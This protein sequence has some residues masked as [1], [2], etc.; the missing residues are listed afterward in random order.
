MRKI[1]CI[2]AIA[3]LAVAAIG[4]SE[5]PDEELKNAGASSQ[6]EPGKT[7]DPKPQIQK[8]DPDLFEW[9]DKNVFKKIL[10]SGNQRF[11]LRLHHV[12]GNLEAFN[13]QWNR[14][15]SGAFVDDRSVSVS[16]KNV[17]GVLNF[18][19]QLNNN[20]Y[21]LPMDRRIAL[22]YNKGWLK[23]D[24]GDINA[25]LST[26][27]ELIR[28]TRT[29]KGAQ[30]T[31]TFGPLS[32]S[33][34]Y[35]QSRSAARTI[36]LTGNNT[37]GPY[38]LQAGMIVD[39]SLRVQV[40]G[41]EQ[42]LGQDYTVNI[43]GGTITFERP[44]PPTS[45]I[46]CTYET[47]GF[48]QNRGDVYGGHVAYKV[49]PGVTIG[50][51]H[52]EQRPKVSSGLVQTT[53]AFQGYGPPNTPY[54]LLSPPLRS[55]PIIVTVDGILQVEGVDYYFD[56][57]NPQIMYFTRFMPPTSIIRVT[58]TPSPDP[59]TF[60]NGKRQV[61]GLDFNWQ[62]AKGSALSFSAARSRLNTPTGVQ[63]G[64]AMAAR[65]KLETGRLAFD[66]HW[67]QVPSSYVSV[68][69][70]GFGRNASGFETKLSYNAGGGWNFGLTAQDI[71]ISTPRY[72]GKGLETINGHNRDIRLSADYKQNENQ[73]FYI[74][75]L[76]S[77]GEY[78]RIANQTN[79]VQTGYRWSQGKLSFDFGIGA[80]Q[81]RAPNSKQELVTSSLYGGKLSASYRASDQLSF[82]AGVGL[83]S[84]KSEDK[85]GFGRDISLR[86]EWV[87]NPRLRT[88]LVLS[89]TNSGAITGIGGYTGGYGFGY[90][91]NGFS[92]GGTGFGIGF[93]ATPGNSKVAQLRTSWN[94]SNQLSLDI[95]LLRTEANGDNLSNSSLTGG[96]IFGSWTPS[97][98]TRLT[99]RVENMTVSFTNQPG[100]SNNLIYG[101]SLEQE[102]L[103]KWRFAADYSYVSSGG[104]GLTG[105]DRNV[106]SLFA[107]L[108]YAI[109]QKKRAFAE[110]RKGG[111]SG[112]LPDRESHFGVGYSYDILPGVALRGTYR[113]RLR[114]AESSA[115]AS[116]RSHGLDLELE[117]RFGGR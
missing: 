37:P 52:I 53:E 18:D 86:A 8:G 77:N 27:N 84:I 92:G 109:D 14:G 70:T 82:G 51:T 106:N 48:N 94:P 45:T 97:P 78:N 55:H 111:V 98:K 61:S 46:V 50:A 103:R 54:Y 62:I 38:Y 114:E 15:R 36:S 19:V 26:G 68:E 33:A 4:Q 24:A 3:A 42:R 31:T 104:S 107:N 66:A 28:F 72:T 58:Y 89:D 113:F 59:G 96:S 69:S 29:M 11:A 117:F 39:G 10:V 17:L 110:F 5:N 6:I 13:E 32:I 21:G 43:Y 12:E 101:L 102:F 90:N 85:S 67:M 99:A 16:G 108:T 2:T 65:Y 9:I 105:F 112:Y 80:T 81:V 56:A 115:N 116:Y 64:Q 7:D 22:N 41:V 93:G 88:E 35:T 100:T 40:D 60:G 44:I 75:G 73:S 83:N 74:T 47:M 20:P 25:R 76:T 91:G 63:T 71:N 30:A 79:G 87:P 49:L 23:V 57:L 34:L 1:W 95:N